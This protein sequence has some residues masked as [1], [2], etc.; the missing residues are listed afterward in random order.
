M[1]LFKIIFVAVLLV[2]LAFLSAAE[3]AVTAASPGRMLKLK[4]QGNKRA[5][6]ALGLL[7]IKEKIISSFLIANSVLNTVCTTVAAAVL[8]SL[9]GDEYGMIISSV[10]M[11]VLMIVFTEVL[12]KSIAIAKSEHIVLRFSRMIQVLLWMMRPIN[13]A[14]DLALRGFCA[15]FKINLH[16]EVTGADEVRGLIEHHHQEGNVFKAD[17]DMLGSIFDIRDMRVDEIMI[18]RSDIQ[19]INIDSTIN[20]IIDQAIKTPHTRIP[21]WQ[22]NKDN[23][24]GVLHIKNLL[25]QLYKNHFDLTKLKIADF[26]S[27]PW[28]VPENTL[29]SHQLHDFREKR[30]HFAVVVD[31]YGDLQGIVTLEDILEEI[32]GQIDDEHD[33]VSKKI[34]AKGENKFVIDG[35][36]TIRDVNRELGWDLPDEHASTI[37]GLVMHELQRLPEEGETFAMFNLSV[38]VGKK[39]ANRIKTIIVEKLIDDEQEVIGR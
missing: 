25:K 28:F 2:I 29:V 31:E 23:I 34:V 14:L 20:E 35:S 6:L 21:L 1:L 37:A 4:S 8:I 5:L 7:K 27:K 18:H 11:S 9:Y 39:H 12:P 16:Q 17:R 22:N 3:T 38:V 24:V 32:V 26:V 10:V 19:T 33:S 13:K 36:M 15:L 30:S